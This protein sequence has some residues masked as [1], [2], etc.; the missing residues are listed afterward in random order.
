MAVEPSEHAVLDIALVR[1][2]VE[3]VRL[4]WIF[5]H[6]RLFPQHPQPAIEFETQRYRDSRVIFTVQHEHRRPH[7]LEHSR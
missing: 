5:H 7:I 1:W 3:P 4:A 6:L 2:I